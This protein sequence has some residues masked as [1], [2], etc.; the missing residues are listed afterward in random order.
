MELYRV[1]NL[2]GKILCW[3]SICSLDK[4]NKKSYKHGSWICQDVTNV[5]KT[6]NPL[7]DWFQSSILTDR[8][9]F[10][11]KGHISDMVLI[12]NFKMV[13]IKFNIFMSSKLWIRYFVKFTKHKARPKTMYFGAVFM[14]Y[15]FFKLFLPKE[16]ILKIFPG[17]IN[18]PSIMIIHLE[19]NLNES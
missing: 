1:Y 15:F 19:Y 16:K 13:T 9:N 14:Q 4:N 7:S 5:S 3:Y 18:I 12:C 10:C 6:F 17:S 8:S 11:K 2:P